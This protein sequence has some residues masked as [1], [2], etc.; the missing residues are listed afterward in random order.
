MENKKKL[1]DKSAAPFNNADGNSFLR[2]ETRGELLSALEKNIKCEV[3]ASNEEFT[4]ICL[5]GWLQFSNFKTYKSHN[6]G[7][8]IYEATQNKPA[9][10]NHDWKKVT[11]CLNGPDVYKCNK[12]GEWTRSSGKPEPDAALKDPENG[13]RYY[14]N[15]CT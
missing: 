13:E 2:P 6:E 11:T 5:R 15:I 8:V 7:W 9:I 3:V 10:N 1:T 12:C 4:S 14:G